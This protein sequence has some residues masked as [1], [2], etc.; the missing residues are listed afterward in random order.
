M[1]YKRTIYAIGG[2]IP[3]HRF[4]AEQKISPLKGRKIYGIM[5]FS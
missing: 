3:N 2:K 4:K 5:G 1:L